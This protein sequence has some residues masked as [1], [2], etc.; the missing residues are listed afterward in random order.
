[1]T[2]TD[3]AYNKTFELGRGKNFSI[4]EV[5]DMFNI[6]PIYKKDR[7]GETQETLA[8]YFSAQNILGWEPKINLEDY[9]KKLKL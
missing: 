7:P 1:M 2:S 8:K 4:N 6:K 3:I 9:I 5:A